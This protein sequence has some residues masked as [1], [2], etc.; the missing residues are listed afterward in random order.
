ML[1]NERFFCKKFS[2]YFL[3]FLAPVFLAFSQPT[4]Y[5]GIEKGLSNNSVN[6]IYK[7]KYGFMWFGTD[8]GLNR[9]DGYNFKIF[10]NQ[11]NDSTSLINN[12]ITKI[13][14][15]KQGRLFIGTRNG[16][17]LFNDYAFDFLP[18]YFIPEDSGKKTVTRENIRDLEKDSKG[19]LFAGAEVLGLLVFD[20]SRQ[21][22]KQISYYATNKFSPYT[23]EALQSTNDGR[24]WLI[25]QNIGLGFYDSTSNT[26]KLVNDSIKKANCMAADASQNLWIGTDNGLY[27]F[28][29]RQK[30]FKYYGVGKGLLSQK[31]VVELTFDNATK[32]WI[33]TDG[34]GINVLD[35]ETDQF[36]YPYVNPVNKDLTSYAITSLFK[37]KASRWWIG[38]LRGGVNIIDKS[39][40]KFQT[41]THDPLNPNSLV[42]NF[43]LSF[44][45]DYDGSV[46]IGTDGGGL[47]IWN[48]KTNTYQNFQH[49]PD[50][51]S[52]LNNNNVT[53]IIRDAGNN[54]WIA[55]YGGGV[56]KYNRENQ[57]FEHYNCSPNNYVWKLYE[58]AEKN[59]WA[60]TLT[61]GNLYCF[62]SVNKQFEIYDPAIREVIS[63]N[64]DRAGTLWVGTFGYLIRVDKKNKKHRFFN[65]KHPVRALHEDAH[66]NFWIGTQGMGLLKFNKKNGTF[67]AFTET[68]GLTNNSVH[69]IEEDRPGNLWISTY[70]G[71][72]KFN[73]H[74]QEFKNFY[75][76][77]GLQSN[78][79]NYN[80]SLRLNSGELL[81]GGIKGF[82][83]F[84]PDSIRVNHRFPNLVLTGLR[85]FNS[86][87]TPTDKIS[88][89]YKS[90]YHTAAITLPYDKAFISFDYSAIEYS[91][92]NKINYAYF[93]EGWDKSWNKVGN[94]RTANYSRLKEGNYTLRIKSTNTEGIWNTEERVIE[95]TVLPPWYRS[96]W[97]YGIYASCLVGLLYAY[98]LY[99]IRQVQLQYQIQIAH[100][101]AEKE[102]ELNERKLTF[103][104]NVSHEFRTP[105]T[106][107]INP[108]KDLVNR[109]QGSSDYK[110]LSVVYRNARRL[111]SLVDQLLLF[112]KADQEE[113][114]LK[115]ARLNISQV[116]EET[117]LCFV[118]QAKTKGINYVLQG[119][120]QPIEVYA[121]REKIEIVLFNLLSN[122]FKFT[123]TN[124]KISLRWQDSGEEI[125]IAIKDNGCGIP[126]TVGD[127][128]FDRFYQVSNRKTGTSSGFGIGLYLV[129]KFIQDHQGQISYRSLENA[130]T[131]FIISLP[132]N[133]AHISATDVIETN[134]QPSAFL[135]ELIEEVVLEEAPAEVNGP[136][137]R[138]ELAEMVSENSTML[139]V[140]DNNQIRE[141]VRQIFKQTF[142][143]YEADNGEI[144]YE[145]ALKYSPDI[146]ISDILMQGMSGLELCSKIKSNSALNHIPVILFTASSSEDIKLQGLEGGAD[147]YITKP[148]EKEILIA[149]VQ[150]ILK[151]RNN[152][153]RYF[154]NEIT[155]KPN[156]LKISEEYSHFLTVCIAIIEENLDD[157]A[158]NIQVF[159]R[160][161]GMSHSNLYKKVKAISGRSV[162][163]FMRFIRLRKVAQLLIDT[164]CN[165]I[166]AASQVGFND[167]KHFR[168]QF[169][170][171]FGMNPS[172]YIKRYRQPFHKHVSLNEKIIKSGA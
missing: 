99:Q 29:I 101:K 26:I 77:D 156:N 110:E 49:N 112:R 141:Y 137:P 133:P 62:N 31:R 59:L 97:A 98:N 96:W 165:V 153:Q 35:L 64:E 38:T 149:R 57:T 54:I 28:D 102:K 122:A 79:F 151:S 106:L 40:I 3:L 39:K 13:I 105:L 72:S 104:T 66:G 37:D 164:D 148:F 47:S 80:A 42:N 100:I 65:I 7:D 140:E 69:T 24:V 6:T 103:F 11:I 143:I 120:E 4:V 34:G 81:F 158:F 172:D 18:T 52:S 89:S 167:M 92:P 171:L 83:I 85:I 73:P 130:G 27:K 16:I 48:R 117:F 78:Q 86:P 55:T 146:I 63:I 114:S 118:Q 74:Q 84:Y 145:Q 168:E 71:I 109:S 82:N 61:G 41:I 20:N 46:W 147:D 9:Y 53:S 76:T 142:T 116:C 15:D 94:L 131:E 144:G 129:K 113:N 90:L 50:D 170:K 111:L 169:N 32:L 58:D 115:V 132:K 159:A 95:I 125:E 12:Q 5:L 23:V 10:R 45:E 75:E 70:N 124:G 161:M 22:F 150:N 91:S 138:L 107:I 43:A 68:K 93:L 123:P 136:A 160:I 127:K 119:N 17:S 60:G 152:L 121:D 139:L 56:N 108:I 25:L 166:E 51:P 19:T 128:L 134:G 126:A 135:E 163:D 157:P 67:K 87:V 155:L 1:F 14:E 21:V 36:D 30:T 88:D 44:C 2:F 154:Y 8:D 33:A 162:N